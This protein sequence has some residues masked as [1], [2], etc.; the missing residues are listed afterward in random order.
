MPDLITDLHNLFSSYRADIEDAVESAAK[1]SAEELVRL[2]KQTAPKRK[3]NFRRAIACKRTKRMTWTW[4]VKS[5]HYRLTHLL[6]HG[7]E[8]RDGSRTAGDPFL[9]DAAAQV[10]P[11]FENAVEEAISNES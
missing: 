11:K 2:T 4:Y 7:H 5:P 3:G 10:T 6:V 1:R 8:N 9:A